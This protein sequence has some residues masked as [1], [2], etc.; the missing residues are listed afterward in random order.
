M[1]TYTGLYIMHLA[2]NTCCVNTSL[3]FTRPSLSFFYRSDKPRV[4]EFHS[5]RY[6][7]PCNPR[8][9]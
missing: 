5:R 6:H 7:L 2:S 8:R 4:Y 1:T 9:L 3:S